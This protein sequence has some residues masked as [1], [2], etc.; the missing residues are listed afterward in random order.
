MRACVCARALLSSIGVHRRARHA[1][2][3]EGTVND[4]IAAKGAVEFERGGAVAADERQRLTVHG[5]AVE[6]Q[7]QLPT[8]SARK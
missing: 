5:R 7:Y 4:N 2:H 1:S 6:V 3:G 8:G